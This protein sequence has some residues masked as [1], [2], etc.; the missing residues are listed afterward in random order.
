MITLFLSFLDV[1]L[2][3]SL[4]ISCICIYNNTIYCFLYEREDYDI[5]KKLNKIDNDKFYCVNKKYL[6]YRGIYPTFKCTEIPDIHINIYEY[7]A[8]IFD[9][10]TNKCIAPTFYERG[11]KKLAEKLK[12]LIDFN[13]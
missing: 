2:V 11:S 8:A 7:G 4:I 12:F 6:I 5:F 9:N 10:K 13:I 1:I 3:V